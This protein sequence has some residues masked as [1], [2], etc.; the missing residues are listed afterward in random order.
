MG[1]TY[2]W[3]SSFIFRSYQYLANEI[4]FL[5]FTFHSFLGQTYHKLRISLSVPIGILFTPKIEKG[6]WGFPPHCVFGYITYT[7]HH[8]TYLCQFL[9]LNTV[10]I[11]LIFLRVSTLFYTFNFHKQ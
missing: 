8:I 9:F 2:F 11:F 3:I 4:Y 7:I 1:L 5:Y 6:D 10:V